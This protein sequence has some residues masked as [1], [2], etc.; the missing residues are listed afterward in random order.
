MDNEQLLKIKEEKIVYKQNENIDTFH[1]L[2]DDAEAY[3]VDKKKELNKM[4]NYVALKYIKVDDV[5]NDD[6]FTQS[7]QTK[8]DISLTEIEK[9]FAGDKTA[10]KKEYQR[11][12]KEN[13]SLIKQAHLEDSKVISQYYRKG[14]ELTNA[15]QDL[16]RYK[17]IHKYHFFFFGSN[18][19]KKLNEKK[20]KQKVVAQIR[21]DKRKRLKDFQEGSSTF[22]RKFI[23][24]SIANYGAE[25]NA[26]KDLE[27]FYGMVNEI[28]PKQVA[29]G[30]L[31][32]ENTL[33]SENKLIKNGEE[34]K[35]SLEYNLRE[36]LNSLMSYSE[37]ATFEPETARKLINNLMR[38]KKN[39]GTLPE[40]ARLLLNQ[41]DDDLD[42]LCM[43]TEYVRIMLINAYSGILR[44][45]ID[46]DGSYI[47]S[48]LQFGY[49][50]GIARTSAYL[51]NKYI[52][53]AQK[54]Q[55]SGNDK[56]YKFRKG[57]FDNLLDQINEKYKTDDKPLYKHINAKSNYAMKILGAKAW[58]KDADIEYA[59]RTLDYYELAFINVNDMVK[60]Y[61]K[62]KSM[63]MTGFA[64]ELMTTV[65]GSE[66][67]M[68][69]A[70][71]KKIMDCYYKIKKLRNDNNSDKQ[72]VEIAWKELEAALDKELI[73]GDAFKYG[74]DDN[75]TE[76]MKKRKNMVRKF[77]A[78]KFAKEQLREK[79]ETVEFAP[80]N[81]DALFERK[82]YDDIF[83][84]ESKGSIEFDAGGVVE[85][86]RKKL[87]YVR[88]KF[89][90]YSN[91]D[92]LMQNFVDFMGGRMLTVNTAAIDV[93][94]D[95]Y[96]SLNS[97][98]VENVE[99]IAGSIKDLM[100]QYN[101]AND[102]K[103]GIMEYFLNDKIKQQIEN[104]SN[105]IKYIEKNILAPELKKLKKITDTNRQNFDETASTRRYSLEDWKGLH[106]FL[107]NHICDDSK[108]FAER[109]R[110]TIEIYDGKRDMVM[111]A[112]QRS[113][114][115]TSEDSAGRTMIDI[116]VNRF[117]YMKDVTDEQRKNTATLKRALLG[118]TDE[119]RYG[120]ESIANQ[121]EYDKSSNDE[122][123]SRKITIQKEEKN[124]IRFMKRIAENDLPEKLKKLTEKAVERML[125]SGQ[126]DGVKGLDVKKLSDL[127]N[128]TN[129]E[130]D[131]LAGV[132][133]SSMRKVGKKLGNTYDT[134]SDTILITQMENILL[135]EIDTDD[136]NVN[137]ILED[138]EKEQK[139][140]LGMRVNVILGGQAKEPGKIYY[141]YLNIQDS[142][143]SSFYPADRRMNF[144]KAGDAW[145]KLKKV[146]NQ[147]GQNM[148]SVLRGVLRSFGEYFDQ[149]YEYNSVLGK[150]VK[151]GKALDDKQTLAVEK[152]YQ[153]ELNLL[154]DVLCKQDKSKIKQLNDM[155][156]G[157]KEGQALSRQL[158]EDNLLKIQSVF[159]AMTKEDSKF[160]GNTIFNELMLCQA[161]DVLLSYGGKYENVFLESSKE[162][163]QTGLHN[164]SRLVSKR[165]GEL[166][167]TCNKYVSKTTLKGEKAQEEKDNIILKLRSTY[168][169]IDDP[170]EIIREAI[171]KMFDATSLCNL[172]FNETINTLKK[173]EGTEELIKAS[174]ELQEE[175]HQ[176][177]QLLMKEPSSKIVSKYM[178]FTD[179]MM[180]YSGKL[181]TYFVE[182]N[183]DAEGNEANAPATT[184]NMVYPYL[185]KLNEEYYD[186][187]KRVQ[188]NTNKYGFAGRRALKDAVIDHADKLNTIE[189]EEDKFNYNVV[190]SYVEEHNLTPFLDILEQKPEYWKNITKDVDMDEYLKKVY[191]EEFKNFS[192]GIGLTTYFNERSR[193]FLYENKN[194]LAAGKGNTLSVKEWTDKYQAEEKKMLE[195]NKVNGKKVYD[196]KMY[197]EYA[198]EMNALYYN[199]TTG[200]ESIETLYDKEQLIKTLKAY[201]ARINKNMEYRDSSAEYKALKGKKVTAFVGQAERIDY[202]MV[203]DQFIQTRL[204]LDDPETFKKNFSGYIKEVKTK[205]EFNF[206]T[207]AQKLASPD[208]VRK[209][210]V[211]NEIN[212]Y[213]KAGNKRFEIDN[214]M[215]NKARRMRF[216]GASPVKYAY[217]SDEKKDK[218]T[219][220]NSFSLFLNDTLIDIKN[221]DMSKYAEL[222]TKNGSSEIQN[223][224]SGMLKEMNLGSNMSSKEY[225]KRADE[226]AEIIKTARKLKLSKD[227]FEIQ[228]FTMY[229]ICQKK[230]DKVE[231]IRE[232]FNNYYESKNAIE[233]IKKKQKKYTGDINIA[234]EFEDII[235]NLEYLLYVLPAQEFIKLVDSKNA[236]F[237]GLQEVSSFCNPLVQKYFS[238]KEPEIQRAIKK[239]IE[240]YMMGYS[241]LTTATNAYSIKAIK[242]NIS[243]K[244][245]NPD[246]REVLLTET[247]F[248]RYGSVSKDE[249]NEILAVKG[250]VGVEQF[251]KFL[252]DRIGAD[253]YARFSNLSEDNKMLLALALQ[254]PGERRRT[255]ELV[256]NKYIYS[257]NKRKMDNSN[258]ANSFALILGGYAPTNLVIFKPA[259]ERLMNLQD[260]VNVEILNDAID[261]VENVQQ[262]WQ[263]DAERDWDTLNDPY[264]S[265]EVAK[266]EGNKEFVK[267]IP[268][269]IA[270]EK[271]FKEILLKGIDNKKLKDQISKLNDIEVAELVVLLQN[272]TIVDAPTDENASHDVVNE[273]MRR[274]TLEM[275]TTR[276]SR[277]NTL[278]KAR[279]TL[280]LDKAMASL[281]SYQVRDDVVIPPMGILEKH[282]VK[283]ALSRKTAIDEKLLENALIL[284]GKSKNIMK[285][286]TKTFTSLYNNEFKDNYIIR[287]DI[288][289]GVRDF[290]ID[291]ENIVNVRQET[292]Y[293]DER[294]N[295]E[296]FNNEKVRKERENEQT[297]KQQYRDSI[298]ESINKKCEAAKEAHEKL[299]EQEENER[300]NREAQLD[301]ELN[302]IQEGT[303]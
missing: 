67:Y 185:Q 277:A 4:L 206:V 259:M 228:Q 33:F 192:E 260:R 70:D 132:I 234:G 220:P 279:E 288:H 78:I 102:Y 126:F 120:Y 24:T 170:D 281:Y 225:K 117:A 247:G 294:R 18:K 34:G 63:G 137:D 292:Y 25:K 43:E 276:E 49:L 38:Y 54:Y 180:E 293:Q 285:E 103:N 101:I 151:D 92:I 146:K 105:D 303:A 280:Y 26:K 114:A 99:K 58:G 264:A 216:N 16:E 210:K 256:S 250:D 199:I 52:E 295:F 62:R 134:I 193:L 82:S 51:A 59:K 13:E 109:L 115:K 150:Y 110:T 246:F 214:P 87:Q 100:N 2:V 111:G 278:E 162:K 47:V 175:A 200:N 230:T 186:Y 31:F 46:K 40:G 80:T 94:V 98:Y 73:I 153:N 122:F 171:D 273:P 209:L 88:Q 286:P 48:D 208:E 184:I 283:D 57:R 182:R 301:E 296:I 219:N 125:D 5:D 68:H 178:E 166:E 233:A 147:N 224:I 268:Q 196:K 50:D 112:D 207:K 140:A 156:K 161:E 270:D 119:V 289:R 300:K 60:E 32:A 263:R 211:K 37:G 160:K 121:W 174:E 21:K 90:D 145:S 245:E 181:L 130:L 75:I 6:P 235:G 239:K 81:F 55:I 127:D 28:M 69:L 223:F 116:Q 42:K 159:A 266:M 83:G 118:Y 201:R 237:D 269:N 93:E 143:S 158:N 155:L 3:E 187:E 217:L 253:D 30:E 104:H 177:V 298:I 198:L 249:W 129:L 152:A 188:E 240:E 149:K 124:S 242:E 227:D 229:M 15:E 257:E 254:I 271:Q 128:L 194:M 72:T 290:Y 275:L 148:D 157:S 297:L 53:E 287:K 19:R 10:A 183:L 107:C 202:K 44:D 85:E 191:E 45:R 22:S 179:K 39:I 96:L 291:V 56:L 123:A 36:G 41:A 226:I 79:F 262:R 65:T 97:N 238:D 248:Q 106:E 267:D 27:A 274:K 272:R 169:E 302:K 66:E 299:L 164:I 255:D 222:E 168:L 165:Y 61:V 243:L 282:L 172:Q 64:K 213:V 108:T 20:N 139:A 136:I 197:N 1:H 203:F 163:Y 251:D 252:K 212:D 23:E 74:A 76:L 9:Q 86:Y 144:S 190:L 244:L 265:I 258:I 189:L 89:A 232:E 133:R 77:D 221:V 218:M 195:D 215:M 14:D 236:Y 91:V 71:S 7:Y 173:H 135:N 17:D 284:L 176:V 204:S 11:L 154:A 142:K 141:N 84:E 241:A 205:S 138:V 231:D 8:D 261:F 35:E 131:T 113:H 167:D 95:Y 12:L 29:T